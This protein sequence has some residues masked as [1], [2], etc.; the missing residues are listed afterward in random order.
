[1]QVSRSLRRVTGL[2]MAGCGLLALWYGTHGETVPERSALQSAIGRVHAVELRRAGVVF[3]VGR[4]SCTYS[5]AGKG[6]HLEDVAQQLANA[7]EAQ[8]EVLYAA[9]ADALCP[10]Y[11]LRMARTPLRTYDEVRAAWERDNEAALVI[12]GVLLLASAVLLVPGA[13]PRGG[14]PAT[15]P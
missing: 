14:S 7:E 15:T 1:M 5:Y 8:V 13:R 10:V 9:G 6:R 2:V 3:K 4:D 11:E 12:G